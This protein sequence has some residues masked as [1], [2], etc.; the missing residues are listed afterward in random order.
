MGKRQMASA[1]E[2]NADGSAPT[3]PL[4]SDKYYRRLLYSSVFS[5]SLV[6]ILP[7][8]V[9]TVVNYYQYQDA[10]HVES[11]RPTTRFISNAKLSLEAFLSER[12]SAL[13][14][15]I[16]TE[17]PEDLQDPQK[18]K[19][20]LARMKRAFGGFI[21]L[22]LID[23]TGMQVSYA[24]PY[25]LQG[26]DYREQDWFH[27]VGLRGVFISDLFGGLPHFAI[28]VSFDTHTAASFVLRATIDTEK[29][30]RQIRALAM[31][32]SNDAFLINRE[33]ILQTPSRFYGRA[34]EPCPLI[35]PPVSTRAEVLEIQDEEGT[36]LIIGYAFI[37]RSPFVLMLLR[38][39]ESLQVGW[40]SLRRDLA[41]FL[42]I[43]IILILAV[44]FG[45]SR[46]MVNR[47]RQADLKRAALNHNM[48]YTNK[49]AAI[50]R[51]ASGVAHEINN[52]LAIIDQKAGLHKDLLS[53]S[54]E[55]PPK[56]RMID[57]VDAVLESV[58]RCGAIT[59][60]LLGFAKHV[61]IQREEI[62]LGRLIKGV[63]GFLE[64]EAAYRSL[65]VTFHIEEGVPTIESDRGQLQ[66]V[67]LNIVNNAF[68]AVEDGGSIR[69]SIASADPDNVAISV[70]DNGIG[71][72]E[73]D[74]KHLFEPFFT[75]KKE[76]GTGLG[77][78][79]TYGIVQ[80]LGGKT[81]VTSKPG[82][83]TC[84]I[85]ILPLRWKNA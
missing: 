8:V 9:M 44:V 1:P 41:L 43:S 10:F 77:L 40:L 80:K 68:A 17:S 63:L 70:C 37:E 58:E 45:G 52:P 28:A 81:R 23:S 3:E 66:Q 32:P 39:P 15:V 74:L 83:G 55:L 36:P 75:T 22:G 38:R 13:S 11:L 20:L 60:R 48:E 42:A 59:H 29:I 31:T 72:E 27:E 57:L 62:D 84:F 21:D 53:L 33:G 18:L 76:G 50:G 34:L 85:V 25:D 30:V 82:E 64:K 79:I 54:D 65:Q 6:A 19:I 67:F 4:V 61:D 71:I 56:E 24:G 78:S 5:V 73:D 14:L 35:V 46:Y 47:T 7:L 69:I 49:M 16:Q 26:R 51:L 2:P 12:I